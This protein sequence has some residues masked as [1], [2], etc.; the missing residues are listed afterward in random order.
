[1]GRRRYNKTKSSE[2]TEMEGEEGGLEKKGTHT[3]HQRFGF[4]RQHHKV[5]Y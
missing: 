4:I 1:M 2:K 5:K 3:Q